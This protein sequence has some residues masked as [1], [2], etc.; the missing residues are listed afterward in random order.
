[1]SELVRT[2][3]VCQPLD[4]V[5]RLVDLLERTPHGKCAADEALR[6]AATELPVH[7]VAQLVHLLTQPPRPYDGADRVLRTAAEH[8]PVAEVSHLMLLLHRPPHVARSGTETTRTAAGRRP[9]EELAQL[10]NSLAQERADAFAPEASSDAVSP[11]SRG[12]ERETR[13][14]AWARLSFADDWLSKLAGAG[15][16]V[17]GAAYAPMGIRSSSS[18]AAVAVAVGLPAL[19]VL[20]GSLLFLRRTVSR[21]VAGVLISAAAIAQLLLGSGLISGLP[22][23]PTLRGTLLPSLPA[24]VAAGL[25]VMFSLAALVRALAASRPP[26]AGA[27]VPVA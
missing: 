20:V 24:Y 1:M 22:F 17:C 15:L 23:P 8:R 21:L 3:V 12:D 13:R 11:A 7:E 26:H 18:T 9:V 10:I 14:F 2:A 25:A 4:A 16:V 19:C 5:A 27:P 6:T